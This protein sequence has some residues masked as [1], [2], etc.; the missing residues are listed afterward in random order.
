MRNEQP[1]VL[2]LIIDGGPRRL[3]GA[4]GEAPSRWEIVCNFWEKTSYFNA[5]ESQFACV[6]NHFKELDF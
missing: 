6:Y 2:K 5:I 3:W 1:S 4:G